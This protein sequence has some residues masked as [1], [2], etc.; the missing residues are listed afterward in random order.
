MKRG[1]RKIRKLTQKF[2]VVVT[3]ATKAAE[4]DGGITQRDYGEVDGGR[5]RR[6]RKHRRLQQDG[7]IFR[8]VVLGKASFPHR[9]NPDG[10]R[11]SPSVST[12]K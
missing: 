3:E 8:Q 12:Q 9:Y 11:E 6:K 10:G 4:D 1:R 7:Q 2:K 5:R